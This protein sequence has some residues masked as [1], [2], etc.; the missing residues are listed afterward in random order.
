MELPT[1][2]GPR[3]KRVA[4]TI[5]NSVQAFVFEAGKIIVAISVVLWVLAS[6]G[7]G[8]SM[9]KVAGRV[10][11]ENPQLSGIP[12]SNKIASEKLENSYAGHFGKFIEPVIRPLGYD[13]KIGLP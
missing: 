8:D 4:L 13:W 12:L 3:F 10:R 7:P 5:W 9:S 2:K 1:Y 6:Y 11:V